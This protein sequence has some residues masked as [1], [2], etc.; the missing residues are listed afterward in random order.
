MRLLFDQN[1]SP[2]LVARLADLC[3]AASHVSLVGLDRATDLVVWQYARDNDYIIVTKD[4]DFGDYGLV[5]GYPPKVVWLRLGNCTT[6][7]IEALI[8]HNVEAIEALRD[9]PSV[10]V[11]ALI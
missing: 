10:G 4:A 8:R 5:R 2:H 6:S 7:Q 11:L 9:D 1:T 3:P